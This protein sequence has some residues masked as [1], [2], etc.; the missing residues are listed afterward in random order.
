MLVID[1]HVEAILGFE[2][3][4]TRMPALPRGRPALRISDVTP[5]PVFQLSFD[6]LNLKP[7]ALRE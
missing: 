7:A 4:T 3:R 1:R 6:L 2:L 5:R